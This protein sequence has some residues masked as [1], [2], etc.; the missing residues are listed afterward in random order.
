MSEPDLH[1]VTQYAL[2]IGARPTTANDIIEFLETKNLYKILG[3]PVEASPDAIKTAFRKKAMLY[4]PDRCAGRSDACFKH[5]KEAFDILN[6]PEKRKAYDLAGFDEFRPVDEKVREAN[7]IKLATD[8]LFE[9][10]ANLVKNS[11]AKG[12]TTIEDQAIDNAKSALKEENKAATLAIKEVSS[13]TRLL[14]YSFARLK[15]KNKNFKDS[16][17][18]IRLTSTILIHK[19]EIVRLN[20]KIRTVTLALSIVDEYGYEPPPKPE[21]NG[22]P[23]SIFGETLANAAQKRYS[24]TFSLGDF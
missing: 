11:L 4:H 2:V 10:L 20:E 17:L 21:P 19:E 8:H 22:Y 12:K 7:A 16:L 9:A 15:N 14:E 13:A 1:A 6:D 3:V 18:G 24:S 5:L 23:D